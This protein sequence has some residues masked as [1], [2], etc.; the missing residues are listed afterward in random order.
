MTKEFLPYEL[1]LKIKELG[2]DK[3]C[4]G[5]YQYSILIFQLPLIKSETQVQTYMLKEDCSAPTFS[6]AFRWFREKYNLESH[7]KKDW[8]DG[9]CLGYESMIECEDGIIDCGTYNIYEEAELACLHKLIE[10]VELTQ[11][12]Q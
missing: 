2:F 9:I 7:I 11:P 6:Q 10:I 1:A 8:Q 4:F 3:L 12:K 5:Y